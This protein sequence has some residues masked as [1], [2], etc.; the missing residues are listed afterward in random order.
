MPRVNLCKKATPAYVIQIQT[1]IDYGMH[2]SGLKNLKELA[3]HTGLSE[4]SLRRYYRNPEM[5]RVGELATL[6]DRLKVPEE[7]RRE[8]SL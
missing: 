5:F 2:L 3:K 7:I 6:L 8:V 4:S 1:T